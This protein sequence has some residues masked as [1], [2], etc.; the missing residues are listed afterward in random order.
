MATDGELA[1]ARLVERLLQLE[2][3]FE[4]LI[5]AVKTEYHDWWGK[6]SRHEMQ[7][8]VNLLGLRDQKAL[9]QFIITR[10]EETRTQLFPD[11]MLED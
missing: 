9:R 2:T 10:G 4:K 7:E 8:F 1:A 11:W 5:D 3:E 6:M